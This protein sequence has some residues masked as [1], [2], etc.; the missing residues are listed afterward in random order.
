MME[1]GSSERKAR[2]AGTG[3]GGR[4]GAV[5]WCRL[6]PQGATSAVGDTAEFWAAAPAACP[7]R[8]EKSLN[9]SGWLCFLNHEDTHGLH[10]FN[11][12]YRSSS[13][14]RAALTVYWL[15]NHKIISEANNCKTQGYANVGFCLYFAINISDM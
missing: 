3:L 12:S 1:R 7:R 2:A 14:Y 10:V 15:V 9:R 8:G 11:Y 13:S 5:T 4:A 6:R